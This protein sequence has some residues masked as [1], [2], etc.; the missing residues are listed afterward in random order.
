MKHT[1][2]NDEHKF[3]CPEY[4]NKSGNNLSIHLSITYELGESTIEG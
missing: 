4:P 3:D 2:G 1:S